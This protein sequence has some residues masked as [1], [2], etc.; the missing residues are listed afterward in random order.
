MSISFWSLCERY[1]LYTN[2]TKTCSINSY[3]FIKCINVCICIFTHAHLPHLFITGLNAVVLASWI[4]GHVSLSSPDSV[5]VFPALAKPVHKHKKSQLSVNYT[6]NAQ[7]NTNVVFNIL[8][9]AY[10]YVISLKK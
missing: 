4:V 6:N 3:S 9:F 7:M 2:T 1:Q 10:L 5:S 8:H